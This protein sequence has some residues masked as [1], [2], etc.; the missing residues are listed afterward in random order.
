M[1]GLLNYRGLRLYWSGRPHTGGAD[2]VRWLLHERSGD[3]TNM[4]R[5]GFST[6]P[7]GSKFYAVRKGKIHWR[8]TGAT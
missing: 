4:G 1:K 2:R 3:E 6:D 5:I 7:I 8:E